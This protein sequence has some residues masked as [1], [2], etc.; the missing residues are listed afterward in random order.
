MF[1]LAKTEKEKCGNADVIHL[2]NSIFVFVTR[3]DLTAIS[4]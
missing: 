2:C 1:H 4:E 3:V